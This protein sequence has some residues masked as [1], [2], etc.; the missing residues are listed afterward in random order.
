MAIVKSEKDISLILEYRTR[1]IADV[2]TGKLDVRE[3][4]AGLPAMM[5]GS[6]QSDLSDLS[7]LSDECELAA[8]GEEGFAEEE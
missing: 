1:L 3:A 2:V 7:G 6:D 5:S 4:A 8:E